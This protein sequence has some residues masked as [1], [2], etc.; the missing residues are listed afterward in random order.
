M[1]CEGMHHMLWFWLSTMRDLHANRAFAVLL[2]LVVSCS[3]TLYA[4]KRNAAAF[5]PLMGSDTLPSFKGHDMEKFLRDFRANQTQVIIQADQLWYQSGG[6]EAL[7]QLAVAFYE[8]LPG[9]THL[10]LLQGNLFA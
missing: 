8:F 9:S 7:V 2:L 3:M 10:G 4:S 5:L 1:L 6:P